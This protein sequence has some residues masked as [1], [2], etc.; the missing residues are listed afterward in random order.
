MNVVNNIKKN[1][2]II[3][4]MTLVVLYFVLKDD[5]ENVL[6]LLLKADIKYLFIALFLFFLSI[7]F[8]SYISYKTV[9]ERNNYTFLESIKHNIIVQFFNGITPFSTGGQPI[10]VYM[11]TKHG[12]PAS[13][14][15]MYILQNFIFYQIAL[16]LFGVLAVGYNAIYH[17]FPQNNLLKHLV[18]IG[19]IINT[20][21]AI[22]IIMIS[23]S[24]KF[25]TLI[26][27]KLIHF[28][29]KIKLVKEEGKSLI[30]WLNR[31]EEFHTCAKDLRKRKKLCILGVFFNILSLVCIYIIPLYIAYSLKD[32]RSLS[33]VSTLTASAYVMLIG[34]FVPIPGA[35]GGIEFGFISFF[36]NLLSPSM[37][38]A[39]LLIWRFITYYFGMIIGAIAFNFDK[40][41]ERK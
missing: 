32:Y 7:I 4:L 25:T 26:V 11:L 33:I 30:S 17:I 15:T 9:N 18:L 38:S 24:K 13:K 37:N 14:G 1:T 34:A 16:V 10:E 8:K 3:F 2:F 27:T 12:V 19:F 21:V 29:S 31:L 39:V 36:G 35:S 6:S 20:V 28:L 23:I 22:G 5:F 40:K 41:E